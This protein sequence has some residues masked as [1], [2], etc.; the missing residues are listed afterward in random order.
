M[1]TWKLRRG[2]KRYCVEFKRTCNGCPIQF[3]GRLKDGNYFYFRAR[4]DGWELNIGET[5]DD[6]IAALARDRPIYKYNG[7]FRSAGWMPI[8]VALFIIKTGFKLYFLSSLRS[9]TFTAEEDFKFFG[10]ERNGV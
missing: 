1:N 8:D 5:K 9:N 4:W 2:M 3:E 10:I 6:A 7:D